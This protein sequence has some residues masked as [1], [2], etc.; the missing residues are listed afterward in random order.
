MNPYVAFF[1]ALN[2][3]SYFSE[4]PTIGNKGKETYTMGR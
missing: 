4:P 3:F 1:K 2:L